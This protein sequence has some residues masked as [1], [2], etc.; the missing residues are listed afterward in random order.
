MTQNALCQDQNATFEQKFIFYFVI[1]RPPHIKLLHKMA[2]ANNLSSYELARQR[3]IERNMAFLRNIGLETSIGTLV[4][5]ASPSPHEPVAKETKTRK[6]STLDTTDSQIASELQDSSRR[7]TRIA[8]M[9]SV[10]YNVRGCSQI[11]IH[12]FN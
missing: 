3:N 5:I 2:S 1:K 4:G 6:R 8:A 7:S 11:T 9:K 12:V 10:N